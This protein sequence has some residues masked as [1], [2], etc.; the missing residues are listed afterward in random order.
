MNQKNNRLLYLFV[1]FSVTIAQSLF[2]S[3]AFAEDIDLSANS[4]DG[5][6]TASLTVA[7]LG[8]E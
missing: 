3:L 5:E 2:A 6:E 4:S 1:V 8:F 7:L